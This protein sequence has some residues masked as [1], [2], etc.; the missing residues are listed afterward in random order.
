LVFSS[1]A[2]A[3]QNISYLHAGCMTNWLYAVMTIFA[4]WFN[5]CSANFGG[6]GAFHLHLAT[7]PRQQ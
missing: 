2:E 4:Q 1:N 3:L 5:I 7:R 6:D